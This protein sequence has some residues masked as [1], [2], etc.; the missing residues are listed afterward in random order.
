[1]C[2]LG[3]VHLVYNALRDH[4]V[5]YSKCSHSLSELFGLECDELCRY[6]QKVYENAVHFRLLYMVE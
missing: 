2:G 1:M 4:Q 6:V 5:R 3:V